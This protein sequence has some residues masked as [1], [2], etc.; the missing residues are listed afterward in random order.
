MDLN[1]KLNILIDKY[2]DNEYVTSRLNNYIDN[3]LPVFLEKA[4]QLV[5]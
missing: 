2:K 4:E 1:K 3:L 5:R